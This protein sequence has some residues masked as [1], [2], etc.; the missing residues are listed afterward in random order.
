MIST[1]KKR[2]LNLSENTEFRKPPLNIYNLYESLLNG[3]YAFNSKNVKTVLENWRYLDSSPTVACEKVLDL[4]EVAYEK[5]TPTN[6]NNYTKAVTEIVQ[7]VRNA[8]QLQTSIKRRISRV[9]TRITT[10]INKSLERLRDA[11]A[12]N[13]KSIPTGSVAGRKQDAKQDAQSEAAMNSLKSIAEAVEDCITCDRIISNHAKLNRR[14][15]VDRFVKESVFTSAQVK[16]NV[17]EFCKLIDTYQI[18]EKAKFSI[19]IEN[20]LYAYEK[21]HIPYKKQ[22]ILEAATDYFLMSPSHGAHYSMPTIIAEVLS[23][24]TLY[25][26]NDFEKLDIL[27]VV[28][29]QNEKLFGEETSDGYSEILSEGIKNK[30]KN[31]KLDGAKNKARETVKQFKLGADKGINAY[32]AMIRKLFANKPKHIIDETP[33][34]LAILLTFFVV[35]GATSIHAVL[36]ALAAITTYFINLEADAQEADAQIKNYER[37]LKKV[38]SRISKA[39]SSEEKERLEAYKNQLEKDLEKIKDYREDLKSDREKEADEANEYNDLDEAFITLT[40]LD[41]GTKHLQKANY[42]M[43]GNIAKKVSKLKI[44]DIDVITEF[45]CKYPDLIDPEDLAIILKDHKEEVL[46]GNNISKYI[47]SSALSDNITKLENIKQKD[48]EE[49]SVDDAIRDL[50]DLI[51]YRDAIIECLENA[52]DN[53]LLEMNFTNTLNLAIE[54]IKKAA[55]NLSDKEKVISRTIDNSLDNLK[56]AINQAT[57]AEDREAVIRGKILPPASRIIKLAMASAAIGYF[58][59]PA[60]SAIAVIGWFAMSQENRAKERHIILD[61][62]DV[63]LTMCNK[64]IQQAEEKN[65]MKGLRNLLMIKKKLEAQRNKLKYKMKVDYKEDVQKGDNDEND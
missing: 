6:I 38:E 32:N 33:N 56:D 36:G 23:K 50:S 65:D 10:K 13:I 1:I 22:D 61:E 16:D 44:D 7:K 59:H 11:H 14:F 2:E 54:R 62:L 4:L 63:E 28:L 45:S 64:Y 12:G 9:K 18:P 35:V 3:K 58:I 17:I 27:P 24:S 31:I 40:T 25:E 43:I 29:E 46:K 30:F 53:A 39:K 49:A 52:D 5:D 37:H 42:D 26:A 19:A 21:N 15:N 34:V 41:E 60:L 47:R 8:T 48:L 57:A 55:Q 51:I 20:S